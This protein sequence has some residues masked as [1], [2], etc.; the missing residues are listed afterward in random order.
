MPETRRKER[1]GSGPFAR[2]RRGPGG[3][4]ALGSGDGSFAHR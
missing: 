4:V 3:Q 2:H 1:S